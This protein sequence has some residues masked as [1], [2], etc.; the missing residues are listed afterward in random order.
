MPLL[1]SL[2]LM[3]LWLRF[4]AHIQSWFL[5]LSTMTKNRM[6]SSLKIWADYLRSPNTLSLCL[7]QKIILG[8]DNYSQMR[9]FAVR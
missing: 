1:S 5:N 6:S 3:V 2:A 7:L 4:S 8:W 9:I